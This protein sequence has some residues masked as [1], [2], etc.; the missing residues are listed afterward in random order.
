MTGRSWTASCAWGPPS[1]ISGG[2][3]L[4][5]ISAAGC[6]MK[7]RDTEKEGRFLME[8]AMSI[9]RLMGYLEREGIHAEG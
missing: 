6:T 1:L 9:S 5:G 4:A 2:R 3:V 8:T 7:D